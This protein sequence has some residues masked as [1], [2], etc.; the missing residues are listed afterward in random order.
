MLKQMAYSI[1]VP[2]SFFPSFAL[3]FCS[4]HLTVIF[5]SSSHILH[6]ILCHLSVIHVDVTKLVVHADACVNTW[7]QRIAGGSKMPQCEVINNHDG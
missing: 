3:M 5:F 2:P 4:F 1:S 6:P 7:I